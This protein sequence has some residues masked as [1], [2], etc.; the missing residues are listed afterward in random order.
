MTTD[1][2]HTPPTNRHPITYRPGPDR[3]EW[4][5]RTAYQ[6]HT[7]MQALIDNAIDQQRTNPTP[8]TQ[9]TP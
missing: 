5:R 4:L 3:Y 9:D 8:N 6:Q 2:P 1:I 7:T